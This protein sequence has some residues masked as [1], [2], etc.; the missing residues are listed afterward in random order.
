MKWIAAQWTATFLVHDS[1]LTCVTTAKPE[2]NPGGGLYFCG[3]K[4]ARHVC[5]TLLLVSAGCTKPAPAFTGFLDVY[6][7]PKVTDIPIN[8]KIK[9]SDINSAP[10]ILNFFHA[11]FALVH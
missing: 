3:M 4:R 6:L 11:I 7:Q 5:N 10:S 2:S 8:I 1:A 9:I